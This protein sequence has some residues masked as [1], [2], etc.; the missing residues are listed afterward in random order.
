MSK[1][2]YSV[3]FKP[4]REHDRFKIQDGRIQNGMAGCCFEHA[5]LWASCAQAANTLCFACNTHPD[6][7]VVLMSGPSI[8]GV[9]KIRGN[10]LC[11]KC[12]SNCQ[13]KN[14]Q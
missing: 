12:G 9:F 10:I 4:V 6:M 1:P 3:F 7:H 13:F 2:T 8:Q 14:S 11:R 5:R